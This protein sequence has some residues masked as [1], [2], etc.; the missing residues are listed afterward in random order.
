MFTNKNVEKFPRIIDVLQSFANTRMVSLNNHNIQSL[1]CK[2]QNTFL[3]IL[4][5]YSLHSS[6]LVY[7][8]SQSKTAQYRY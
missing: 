6:L 2:H 1:H 4:R 5:V 7:F 8:I 3:N